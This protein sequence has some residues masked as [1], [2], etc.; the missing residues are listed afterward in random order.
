MIYETL[1][2]KPIFRIIGNPEEEMGMEAEI[3]FEEKITQKFSKLGRELD[4]QFH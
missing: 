1:S 4:I 2:D 3:S